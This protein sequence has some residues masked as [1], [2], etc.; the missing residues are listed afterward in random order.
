M[1]LFFAS[2]PKHRVHSWPTLIFAAPSVLR[3]LSASPGAPLVVGVD[4]TL[5][6]SMI[7]REVLADVFGIVSTKLSEILFV[8]LYVKAPDP[9]TRLSGP[10]ESNP[11]QSIFFDVKDEWNAFPK[12]VGVVLG[13]DFLDSHIWDISYQQNDLCLRNLRG[14]CKPC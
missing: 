8:S 2:H 5:T 13:K 1:P 3:Q 6:K 9:R 4:P 14:P 12:D 7:L 11:P 10:H